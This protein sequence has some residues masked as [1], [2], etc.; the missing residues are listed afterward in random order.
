MKKNKWL[1]TVMAGIFMVVILSSCSQSKSDSGKTKDKKVDTAPNEI[2]I[3]DVVDRTV[4][5][6][7]PA[8]K[9]VG[10][11]NPTMN[12]AIILGGGGK[13]V[14]GFGNK[15]MASGL[16]ELVFPE[17]KDIPQIG[18]GKD[19]NY[20]ES[21]AVG[22]DLA[23]LPERF[24]D[25]A[26]KYE[27]V[28]IPAAVVLPNV[29]SF[30]TIKSSLQ[31]VGTLVGE[32]E[33]AKKIVSFFDSKISTAKEI[34]K[35][36][37]T[38]PNVLYLGGSSPLAV[39]NGVMLQSVMLETVGATNVAKDVPGQGDYI[40][41]TIEEIIN[42]NPEVIYVPMFAKYSVEDI[43][44]NEAWSSI[45]AVQDKKVF[46]F[47]S[48][49]EAWDYPTPSAAMGLTWLLNNLYPDLYSMDQV[50]KDANEYYEMVYGQSFSA[51]QLGLK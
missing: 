9:L 33:R 22:A 48:K 15:N 20:E 14:A 38:K 3:T 40:E 44:N 4:T 13:Y 19:I 30:D 16:Y 25:Q 10:T 42:W 18:Q 7:S 34:A 26:D 11:H 39:A 36:A 50:V 27:E 49:L 2:T 47:P 29:E 21:L 46:I 12:L 6:K 28:G 35:K 41:V 45:K 32:E 24:K 23:I 17:L 37:D 43:L 1:L 51:E 31:M 5:L 8:K